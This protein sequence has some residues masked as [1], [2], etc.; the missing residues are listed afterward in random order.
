MKKPI[1]TIDWTDKPALEKIKVGLLARIVSERSHFKYYMVFAMLA[2]IVT[3]IQSYRHGSF[4][5]PWSVDVGIFTAMAL[6]HQYVLFSANFALRVVQ[7]HLDGSPRIEEAAKLKDDGL[8]DFQRNSKSGKTCPPHNWAYKF[9]AE[10]KAVSMYCKMCPH[11][12]GM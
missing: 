8:S 5:F 1:P 7:E 11:I 4:D 10:G 6:W 12:P 3:G 9:D 2:S